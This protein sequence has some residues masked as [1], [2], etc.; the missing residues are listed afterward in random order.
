MPLGYQNTVGV[1]RLA[2]GYNIFVQAIQFS[3]VDAQTIFFGQLPGVPTTVAGA[4]KIHI[5]E[6]AT[7]KRANVY[8]QSV[9]AGSAQAWQMLIRKNDTTD[10]LIAS[11]SLATQE[12]IFENQALSIAMA[13][14]DFF[15][16]K[17]INPTWA[18]NPVNCFF[19]GYIYLE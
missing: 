9:T 1:P 12:R 8:S 18:T 10:T 3:P 15:E 17:M 6:A 2:M 14:G 19:G 5:R 16:I 11:L 13:A 7:I 4:N